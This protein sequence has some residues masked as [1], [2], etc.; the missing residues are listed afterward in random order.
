MNELLTAITTGATAFTATNL[1]DILILLLFFSQV[2]AAFRRRHIVAGQYLGF[3]A[4]VFASLPGFFGSLILPQDWIGLLGI[5]PIAIG[6][7][8][9]VN[10][11][12]DESDDEQ[13]ISRSQNSPF[14]SF[15]SAETYSVAAV[16]VANGS[17]NIS[18]Y[19]PLFASSTW[20]GLV[21]L[22]GVFFTLVG[23][24]CF[25]AYR[26]TQMRAIADTLTRYGNNFV[27]FILMGL[28]ALILVKSHTLESP[29]LTV[30]SL[31]AGCFCV[32]TIARNNSRVPEVE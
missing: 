1:D 23:V 18:I 32:L 26:L 17:D 20:Q 16:T 28:G 9:L 6:F 7:G 31:I 5:L 11:D 4:L 27:P 19:V 13:E 24:W 14:T 2:N 3:T 21:V 10:V 25:A 29:S 12:N 15:L 30:I 8:R 22:L